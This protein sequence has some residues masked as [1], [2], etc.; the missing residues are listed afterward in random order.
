MSDS[1][2]KPVTHGPVT[3][4]LRRPHL[5]LVDDD[6]MALRALTRIIETNQ[7]YW[8]ITAVASSEEALTLIARE[9]FAVVITDLVMSGANGMA[10]LFQLQ[11]HQPA[12][13]RIVHSSHTELLRSGSLGRLAHRVLPKPA[14]AID[15]LGLTAWARQQ[16][17]PLEPPK[18]TRCA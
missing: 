15:V 9:A 4:E 17:T 5:L 6:P 13:I 7:P 14:S 3:G 1:P 11:Q 12:A 18:S 10:V 2:R 8:R 16:S